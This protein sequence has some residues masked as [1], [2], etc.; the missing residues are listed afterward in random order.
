MQKKKFADTKA[1]M[2]LKT[3]SPKILDVLGQ[4]V[5]DAGV[6]SV[7]TLLSKITC[8]LLKTKKWP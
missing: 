2:F 4:I 7:K 5:P 1:G 6:F 3:A 8:Y